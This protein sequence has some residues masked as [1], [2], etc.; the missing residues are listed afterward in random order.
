ME[1]AYNILNSFNLIA[2]AKTYNPPPP[3]LFCPI[4]HAFEILHIQ[5]DKIIF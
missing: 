1:N 2:Y 3:P 5:T 4:F